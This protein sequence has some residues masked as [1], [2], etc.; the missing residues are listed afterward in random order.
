MFLASL[1]HSKWLKLC[2]LKFITLVYM[3]AFVPISYCFYYYGCVIYLKNWNCNHSS[4]LFA[5]GYLGYL[6][7]FVVP[8]NFRIVFSISMK[9]KMGI[10]IGIALN[11]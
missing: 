11:L 7:Y 3:S 6:R 10:L 8:Y 9:N 4:I 2:V 1:S 5:Q